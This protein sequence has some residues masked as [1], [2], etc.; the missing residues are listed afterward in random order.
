MMIAMAPTWTVVA[1]N[2]AIMTWLV[3]I[4]SPGDVR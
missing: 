4:R 1:P 2:K 3:I